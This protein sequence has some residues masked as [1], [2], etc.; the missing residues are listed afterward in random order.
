VSQ[1]DKPPEQLTL[2]IGPR[3]FSAL[4]M[5]SGPVV[6]LLH[7]FPDCLR[8]F[9][10]QLPAFAAAGY[11][12]VAVAMPGYEPG[13]QRLD[14][15][16]DQATLAG[17]VVAL[18]DAL[19]AERVHLV[20]HDWGAAVGYAVAAMAP[21]RLH[22]L[23]T[24]AVPHGG[25][26]MAEIGRHPRQLRLSWYMG[27]F[28]LP[29]LPEKVVR[30]GNF[31]FLRRLWRNWSPGWAF[32]DD[33]FAPVAGTFA[34]PGVVESALAYYRAAVNLRAMLTPGKQ[35]AIFDVPVPTLAMTGAHDGCIDA[36]VF[37][38]LCRDEDFSGGFEVQRIA[39]AGHFLHRER[40]QVV[41]ERI[42]AWLDAH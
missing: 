42:I 33:D 1:Q 9:D 2:A 32:T 18:I 7:G 23:T 28:Q 24:M 40:P 21:Q 22:S 38:A 19:Q 41:N 29:R 36:D 14:G 20:G 6:L 11:R 31:A 30:S 37:E 25:R 3:Y 27:F 15:T 5:G 17:E 4:A 39:E 13:S 35:P 12:A 10:A 16:Y 26:F 8:S 34:Q